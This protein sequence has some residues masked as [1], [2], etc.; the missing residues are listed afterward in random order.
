[1][2]T[3]SRKKLLVVDDDAML[4]DVL[5]GILAE[6]RGEWDM[7]FLNTGEEALE[8]LARSSVDVILADIHLVGMGGIHLL[9]E[10]KSKYPHTIR[11][12]CSGCA[13]PNTIVQALDVAHQYLPKPLTL[14][15]LKATL[16]RAYEL[17]DRL[18]NAALRQLLASIQTLP[19]IPTIYQDLVAAMKSPHASINTAAAIIAKD[20]AMLSKV[21]QVVNSAYFGLRRTISS[22]AHALALLGLDLVKGL[23]LMVKLF[24]QCDRG[25]QLPVPLEQLWRH[26]L[27]TAINARAIATS[28]GA[29]SLA[30]EHAFMAGL[31]HDVGLLVLNTNFPDRYRE[32]FRLIRDDG[33]LLLE[34]EHEV[35][36]ATHADVGAYL[37]GI[38]G[39]HEAIVEAVAFHHDP[40][41]SQQDHAHV[42]AGVHVA[43]VLDEESDRMI[44]G[45]TATEIAHEYLTACHVA[46]RLPAWRETCHQS[47]PNADPTVG[48]H[49]ATSSRR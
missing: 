48:Q 24:E 38:W 9:S 39:L 15:T 19:S 17:Q 32:V 12:A 18:S 7:Q 26:G 45:G 44:T 46:D 43:N 6:I 13:H 40:R 4:L 8:S 35:F 34:S 31:L 1:V 10:I 16:S 27:T 42:L 36:G 41:P 28:A 3:T 5:E 25:G 21:L 14:A 2:P 49:P 47:S 37:L 11:I 20:M 33:R 30:V 22:P 23:V 29:G